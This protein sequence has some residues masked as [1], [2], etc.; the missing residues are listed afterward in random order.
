LFYKL[1]YLHGAK[2]IYVQLVKDF[3]AFY[4][5]RKFITVF[6]RA[7]R[8]GKHKIKDDKLEDGAERRT[9]TCDALEAVRRCNTGNCSEKISDKVLLVAEG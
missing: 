6:T 3:P 8:Q 1:C 9:A 5:T 2:L 4:G 7:E